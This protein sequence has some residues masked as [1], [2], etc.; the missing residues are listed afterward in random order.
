[1]EELIKGELETYFEQG[2]EGHLEYTFVPEVNP[3]AVNGGRGYFL[4]SGDFLRILDVSGEPIWEGELQLIPSRISTLFFRDRHRLD[5]DVW[6][7]RKQKGVSYADWVDWFWAKPP[8][9][10]EFFRK[11]GA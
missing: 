8:L 10:G 7:P 4:K 6:C 11:P 9:K 1:M 5:Y 3:Q 2:Y